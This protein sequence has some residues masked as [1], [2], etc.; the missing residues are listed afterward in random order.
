MMRKQGSLL[1][2]LFAACM[3][4][5]AACT[6]AP[7]PTTT[8]TTTTTT[9]AP[10]DCTARG[11]GVDLQGCDLSQADLTGVDLTGANLYFANLT[12]ANLTQANLTDANLIA[13]NLTGANLAGANLTNANLTN[14]KLVVANLPYANLTGANLGGADLFAANLAGANLTN[15]TVDDGGY[16]QSLYSVFLTS[17]NLTNANLTNANLI[18]ANLINANLISATWSNLQKLS[19]AAWWLDSVRTP[20]RLPTLAKP[21]C[22]SPLPRQNSPQR[23]M[24][25][26]AAHWTFLA[27]FMPS[28][29]LRAMRLESPPLACGHRCHT[30]CPPWLIQQP[31][32]RSSKASKM[33]QTFAS[34]LGNFPPTPERL[35]YAST[36]SLPKILSM[37]PWSRNS[38][39]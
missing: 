33:L 17:A 2:V 10:V 11:P 31:A 38:K 12:Q 37:K 16:T 1:I 24:V 20:L 26:F 7:V 35:A 28:L 19:N 15:I 29:M 39:R 22:P 14:A 34:R 36:S 18:N 32:L 27:G 25:M 23:F 8:T 9:V 5:F 13:T 4:L 3:A 30:T 21:P 6:P